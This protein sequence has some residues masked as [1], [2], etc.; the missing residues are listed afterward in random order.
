MSK[1]KQTLAII[2][3]GRFGSF[4]AKEL[5]DFFEIKIYDANEKASKR[6]INF[7][8]FVPLETA[9]QS[10]YIYL[11]I[12]IRE[13]EN[14]LVNYANII[15]KNSVV[16]DAA[17]IKS[18]VVKWFEKYLRNKNEFMFTHPLF[19]PD[20]GANGLSG[21]SIAVQPGEIT[22]SKYSIMIDVFERMKLN[23]LAL[24]ADEHDYLMAYNLNLIHLL[25]R[26][27]AGMGISK[28][29]L[30]MNALTYLNGM[31]RYVVNDSRT[32]FEDFFRYNPY[33]EKIKK[34]LTENLNKVLNSLP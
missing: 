1:N 21:L 17:S 22:Y 27:L 16:I 15:A 29:P 14:F 25:G 33:A 30:K 2:G 13:I 9:L 32:L 23:V 19:G 20:S 31:S 7:A 28:I 12:P 3:F 10:D 6:E 4:W 34:D 5:S 26:A 11:T 24:S 18:P 8:E